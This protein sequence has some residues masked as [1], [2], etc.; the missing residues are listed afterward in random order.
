M[1]ITLPPVFSFFANT[2]GWQLIVGVAKD[3]KSTGILKD[4][5]KATQIDVFLFPFIFSIISVS[6]IAG[7]DHG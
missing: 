4:A 6:F 5:D 3:K 1:R 7:G 2:S